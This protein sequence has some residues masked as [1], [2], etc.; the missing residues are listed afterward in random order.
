MSKNINFSAILNN[1]KIFFNFDLH[2]SPKKWLFRKKFPGCFL[3]QMIIRTFR[4]TFQ[5]FYQRFEVGWNEYV[6]TYNL[7]YEWLI[8]LNLTFSSFLN[9]LYFS[10]VCL[11]RNILKKTVSALFKSIEYFI[12][13][14]YNVCLSPILR[15]EI[16]LQN[17]DPCRTCFKWK[18]VYIWHLWILRSLK[19]HFSP[20]N[21]QYISIW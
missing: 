4:D 19:T 15:A 13:T 17:T 5:T 21:C 7:T 18:S 10:P 20:Q 8:P 14:I 3:S 9:P 2:F 6:H 11:E 1:C 12:K 16:H